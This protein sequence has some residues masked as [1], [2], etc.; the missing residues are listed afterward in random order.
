MR[1][2]TLEF[3]MAEAEL[4]GFVTGIGAVVVGATAT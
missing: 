2:C 1:R 3:S 4:T